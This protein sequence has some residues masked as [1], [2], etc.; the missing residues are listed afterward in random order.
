M[1]TSSWLADQAF[2]VLRV[3]LLLAFAAITQC[4]PEASSASCRNDAQCRAMDEDLRYCVNRHC[5][6]CVTNAAC[7]PGGDCVEGH[8]E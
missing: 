6:E 8:C 4:A 3:A 2:R 1:S 5:A 7:G